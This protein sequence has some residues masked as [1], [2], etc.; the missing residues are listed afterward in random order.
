M[1]NI[2]IVGAGLA[3]LAAAHALD[4]RGHS[5][6]LFDKGRRPGGRLASREWNGRTFNHGAQFFTVRSNEFRQIADGWLAASVAREWTRGFGKEDGHP[7]YVGV[8]SMNAIAAHWS[9]GLDIECSA[10]V[11]SAVGV[12]ADF[13]GL[14]LTPPVPQSVTILGRDVPELAS[15]EYERCIALMVA[16]ADSG[17]YPRARQT[18]EAEPIPWIA[19]PEQG[20]VVI[21]SSHAFAVEYWDRP[22]PDAAAA[23]LQAAGIERFEA[24]QYHR[25]KFAKPTALYPQRCFAT[26][27]SGKPVVFAGDAFGEARVEGAV[28]SGL[29][30]AA[31][32]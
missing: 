22:Q 25:W 6:K 17:V 8:P 28:L 5:V 16:G 3:G 10:T 4:S 31:T 9:S 20:S 24:W 19:E 12:L 21:H 30:A 13:D 29:A 26:T 27:L 18:P 32:F 1:A 23:L 14:I 7:R 15:I 11:E 2:A